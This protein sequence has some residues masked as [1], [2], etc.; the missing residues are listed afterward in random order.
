MKKLR[1]LFLALVPALVLM[2]T[3]CADDGDNG[4]STERPVDPRCASTDNM[5][6]YDNVS[7][8]WE[9]YNR[10]GLINLNTEVL[11]GN[12]SI[13]VKL[14]CDI[15]L[16][17]S[18]SDPWVPIG[19]YYGTRYLGTFDGDNYTISNLY[20]DNTEDEQGLFGGFEG[21]I[22][23]LYVKDVN[24]TADYY[25]GTIVGTNAGQIINT[26]V[27]DVTINGTDDVGAIT[28][29]NFGLIYASSAN[30]VKLSVTEDGVRIGGIAGYSDNAIMISFVNNASLTVNDN[31]SYV[32][33]VV[34]HNDG[35]GII[36]SFTNNVSVTDNY[37]GT[38]IGGIVG[39]NNNS[40]SII[41]EN[42]FITNDASL[43]G[44][45]STIDNT[46]ASPI[47]NIAELNSHIDDMN[48]AFENYL[49]VY[50][51]TDGYRYK[52]IN[53]NT[54]P[55]FEAYEALSAFIISDADDLTEFR[56]LVNAG[57]NNMDAKLTADIDLTGVTWVPIGTDTRNYLAT[58]DGDNYTISNL[59]INNANSNQALFGYT[60]GNSL[61]KNLKMDN[62]TITT[63]SNFA[64][65]VVGTIRNFNSNTPSMINVHASNV[66]INGNDILGGL[67]AYNAV[68]L[69]TSSSATNVNITATGQAS[70]D[71]SGG[72]VGV[73]D[74]NVVATYANG[75]TIT[76]NAGDSPNIGGIVGRN[77]NNVGT[78]TASY[79]NDLA[80]THLDNN[81]KV[82]GVTGWIKEPATLN[83]NYFVS[84]D[85]ALFG[86]GLIV[87]AESIA[88][89]DNAT[90][91]DTIQE[92]NNNVNTINNA[93]DAF[94]ADN[95]SREFGYRYED[96][97]APTTDIPTFI[98]YP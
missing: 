67:V 19:V 44:I 73:N 11:A 85:N 47:S 53:N 63:T 22:K 41:L 91:V 46:S 79:A 69:I 93:I 4:G 3:A 27:S 50:N 45:G 60:G 84:S 86:V 56:D 78:L 71:G 59:T 25:V 89:V 81:T 26:H 36:S 49:I 29:D 21:V 30:D 70:N 39:N 16:K 24:I 35:G 8:T 82:G 10:Y 61:I 17:G 83:S 1:I 51:I 88:Q 72:V 76:A 92:L 9:I 15:D 28:G 37:T 6:G 14:V 58:F 7:G 64:G 18:E 68:G 87:D 48:K 90:R 23:N 97:I 5:T 62:V 96:G 32:G 66:T 75:I 57:L 34:G 13:D 31:N 55:I 2:V 80:F 98:T 74:S 38:V 52:V 65:A 77:S 12:N 42:Y 20:I 40:N 95:A 43:S 94:V 54:F 33:G